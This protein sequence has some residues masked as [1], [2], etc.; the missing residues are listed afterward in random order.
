MHII[1]PNANCKIVTTNIKTLSS[2][3]MSS[4]MKQTTKETIDSH[5]IDIKNSNPE[6]GNRNDYLKHRTLLNRNN[7]KL[8]FSF[9]DS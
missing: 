7:N 5:I 6:K 9:V 4:N 3:I 8:C 2:H 1:I